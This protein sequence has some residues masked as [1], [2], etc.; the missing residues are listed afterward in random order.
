MG[1]AE[2]KDMYTFNRIF[3]FGRVGRKPVFTNTSGGKP[4]CRISVATESRYSKGKEDKPVWH[5]VHVFGKQAEIASRFLDKGRKVFVEGHFESS[6]KSAEE[7]EGSGRNHWLTADRITFMDPPPLE[8]AGGELF[9][10]DETVNSE[11]TPALT[12]EESPDSIPF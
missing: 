2:V 1:P 11:T 10:R 5:S 7:Q 4:H 8:V 6:D 9:D 12:T 3:I